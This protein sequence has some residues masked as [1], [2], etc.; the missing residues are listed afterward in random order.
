MP[1]NPYQRIEQ[2]QALEKEKNR[3]AKT[4]LV[5]DNAYDEDQW[6]FKREEIFAQIVSSKL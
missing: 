3:L 5:W 1:N 6:G 4:G 2:L